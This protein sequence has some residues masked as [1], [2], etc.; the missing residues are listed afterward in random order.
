MGTRAFLSVPCYVSNTLNNDCLPLAIGVGLLGK[1]SL[2]CF[3]GA[4]SQSLV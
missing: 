1:G 4:F 2:W 3:S